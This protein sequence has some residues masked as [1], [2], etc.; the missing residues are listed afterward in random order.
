VPEEEISRRFGVPFVHNDEARVRLAGIV[1]PD[2]HVRAASADDP[3]YVDRP[4]GLPQDGAALR[5]EAPGSP[6]DSWCIYFTPSTR[7]EPDAIG[8]LAV[9]GPRRRLGV[10]TRG[11]ER[12]TLSMYD[13]AGKWTARD[14]QVEWAAPVVWVKC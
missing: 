5:V 8:R 3:R 4:P 9:T 14:V 7:I 11:I 12:G 13:V 1:G 10:L 2:G 6:L